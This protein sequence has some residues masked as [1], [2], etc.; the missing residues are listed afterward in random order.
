MV[1][2]GIGVGNG[3]LPS[4]NGSARS[5]MPPPN[6]SDLW[7]AEH[8][9]PMKSSYAALL[10]AEPE[11]TSCH[12]KFIGT[13]DYIWFTPQVCTPPV[14]HYSAVVES[15]VASFEACQPD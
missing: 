4:S 5:S 7:I 3:P 12:G 1:A 6:A 8:P 10:G 9:L 14:L 15:R 2:T 11:F 13:V